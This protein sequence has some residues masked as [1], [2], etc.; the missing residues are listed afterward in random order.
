MNYR[1]HIGIL[2]LL[3]DILNI[4]IQIIKILT[5]GKVGK[6]WRVFICLF[7]LNKIKPE[8]KD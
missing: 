5:F 7:C 3:I 2:N 4:L 6:N 1:I 8:Y